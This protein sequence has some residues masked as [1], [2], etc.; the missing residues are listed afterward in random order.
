MAKLG[1]SLSGPGGAAIKQ[2]IQIGVKV[3]WFIHLNRRDSS[4]CWCRLR[5][6]RDE[7]A[8]QEIRK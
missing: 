3:K 8:E 4:S 2:I 5:R 6:V 1:K 7:R